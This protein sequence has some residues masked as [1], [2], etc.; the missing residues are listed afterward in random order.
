MKDGKVLEKLKFEESR[1]CYR[2][3]E[4]GK[5]TVAFVVGQFSRDMSITVHENNELIHTK[6]LR[7]RDRH[8]VFV[9]GSKVYFPNDKNELVEFDSETF[10]EKVL[11]QSVKIMCGVPGQPGFLAV[12]KDGL[13]QTT[14]GKKQLQEE[15]RGKGEC[16]WTAVITMGFD[17]VLAGDYEIG[18]MDGHDHPKTHHFFLLVHLPSLEVVD[19]LSVEQNLEEGTRR[20]SSL[21]KR[22]YQLHAML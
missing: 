14:E 13:L 12:S 17:A 15:L 22:V 9:E 6:Q 20:V 5:K 2:F 19:Q 10:Q 11:M 16:D 7:F 18:V 4:V 1:W 3:D 8:S 21:R